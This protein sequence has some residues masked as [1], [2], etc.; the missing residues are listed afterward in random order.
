[1]EIIL[2]AL[3]SKY[4]HTNLAIR[5]LKE[6]CREFDISI[7]ESSI[8]DSYSDFAFKI[9][10]E[11]P[12]LVGLSCY[13]WNIESTIKLCSIIKKVLPNTRI[14]LGGPEV[15]FNEDYYLENYDF[16]DYIIEGEGEKPFKEFLTE[17]MKE[18]IDYSRVD[19]LVYK[20]NN[21]IIHNTKAKLIAE[22]DTIP[23]PYGDE[24]P[25][26]IL[27]YEAARGCPFGCTYCLSGSARELRFFSLD[28]VKSDLKA[29]IDKE[30]ELVKF[31]DRTFNANK[32]FAK[33]IW[34]FLIQ[35]CGNTKFHFEIALDLIDE[36]MLTLLKE[37]PKGLFQ[38]EIGVQTTN[39]SVLKNINRSMNFSRIK[40]NLLCIREMGN[41]HCHLDLIAG[42]P[43]EDLESF[44]AS[45]EDCMEMMPDVLQL[46]F[47]KILK[48]T[49]LY[50]QKNEFGIEYIPYPN[51]QVLFTKDMSFDNI[52][53][54][55]K[56]EK[57]FDS[58]YNSGVYTRTLYYLLTSYNN[59]YSFF[60]EFT[61][62]L[63]S[64]DFFKRNV[65]YR[66]KL[67]YLFDFAKIKHGQAIVQDLI[68]HDLII[69][70]KKSVLPDF[71]KKEID[72]NFKITIIKNSERLMEI[73][74]TSEMKKI[75]YIQVAIKVFSE[76]NCYIYEKTDSTVVFNIDSGLYCYL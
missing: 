53:Y 16:I 63:S 19:G 75:F 54:L 5:Y 51:Y 45:F 23:F 58:Y 22:L 66:E 57:V 70:T 21:N 76:G 35:N 30:V 41:I 40:E 52:R 25:N 26:K 64:T 46:G 65:D 4:I 38:F 3:N 44:K 74:G 42:L 17:F 1:M 72:K 69:N 24:V 60:E 47:L 6:Y 50:R 15:S 39:K 59:K 67:R 68:V 48:G 18:N 43:G 55:M 34:R 49:A 32:V 73:I 33:E 8:N 14:L 7:F 28:R 37:A 71:L 2:A 29:L 62:Y 10:E 61:D 13:I 27:Y 9:I 20:I 12:R 36:D 56:F 31:V 11:S